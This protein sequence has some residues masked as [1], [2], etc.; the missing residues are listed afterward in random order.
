MANLTNAQTEPTPDVSQVVFHGLPIRMILDPQDPTQPLFCLADVCK[1]LNLS[2]AS[3]T[4]E[5]IKDE[6][7]VPK[8]NLG[9]FNTGYGVKEHTMITEPQLYFVMMRSRAKI[10]RE[11]RQWIVN[12]VL[13]AIRKTG[14]YSIHHT[15]TESLQPAS[16][17]MPALPRLSDRYQGLTYPKLLM[18]L[19]GELGA[20]PEQRDAY[21]YCVNMAVRQGIAMQREKDKQLAEDYDKLQVAYDQLLGDLKTAPMLSGDRAAQV[22][23][24]LDLIKERYITTREKLSALHTLGAHETTVMIDSAFD[25][26]MS[27]RLLLCPICETVVR[28]RGYPMSAFL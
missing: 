19:H 22:L 8:L 3:M 13:P 16:K 15:D 25:A 1:A 12:E 9:S 6:F 11:F 5:Q 20:S 26:A 24:L 28:P 27:L 7:G 10:A 18:L 4:V 23:R 21:N 14:S 17:S 2:N